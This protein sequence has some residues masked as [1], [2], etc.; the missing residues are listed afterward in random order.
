[1]DAKDILGLPK[2]QLPIAQEKKSRPPKEP[3]RKPDGIS[4]E[5]IGCFSPPRSFVFSVVSVT[6]A[7]IFVNFS[8][9]REL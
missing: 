7:Y 6:V 5:V 2:N 8:S 3:Q 1:M 9:Y 4:R